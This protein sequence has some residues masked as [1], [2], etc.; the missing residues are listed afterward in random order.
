VAILDFKGRGTR[1]LARAT[2]RRASRARLLEDPPA[3][4]SAARVARDRRSLDRRD[5]EAAA[6]GARP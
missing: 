4:F 3:G 5:V 6:V 1:A 2:W